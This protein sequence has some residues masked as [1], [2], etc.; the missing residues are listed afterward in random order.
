MWKH[1]FSESSDPYH[2][3]GGLSLQTID[4]RICK[5]WLVWESLEL[6]RKQLE[7]V[8]KSSMLVWCWNNHTR[9]LIKG[10]D[11][12]HGLAAAPYV[13]F[14]QEFKLFSCSTFLIMSFIVNLDSIHIIK[15]LNTICSNSHKFLSYLQTSSFMLG[16]Y[17]VGCIL[18]S[19]GY[20]IEVAKHMKL[21]SWINIFK[22][23]C[24]VGHMVRATIFHE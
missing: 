4:P 24:W 17:Y 15:I 13:L 6:S 7:P 8:W 14:P 2:P 23:Y 21:I 12:N 3:H 20:T 16:W 5:E 1:W 9:I 10:E 11:E 18:V 22:V 19:I